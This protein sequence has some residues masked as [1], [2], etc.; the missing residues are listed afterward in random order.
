M[1]KSLIDLIKEL[2]INTYLYVFRHLPV[3]KNKVMLFTASLRQYNCNPK[4]LTEYLTNNRKDLDLVWV[5]E[6]VDNVEKLLP[7]GVRIVKYFSIR[8]LYEIYTAHYIITNARIGKGMMFS[9]RKNQKYIQLWHSSLRFKTIEQDAQD[10]LPESYII[11]ARKDSQMCDYIVSGSE[12]STKIFSTGFWYDG[13]VLKYGTPRVDY[14]L[15]ADTPSVKRK[16]CQFFGL[17]DDTHII[18]YAPTFRSGD[19]RYDLSDTEKIL[20]AAKKVYGGDWVIMERLHPNLLSKTSLESSDTVNA[21]YYD[22]MQE[23]LV[24]SEVLITDYSSCMFD[25]AYLKRQCI[26][27]VPDLDSYLANERKL[28]FDIKEL[29]F[30]IAYSGDDVAALIESYDDNEYKRSLT[31]FMDSIGSYECGK[32]SERISS[33]L[34]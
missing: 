23:L 25:F 8:Y 26:L 34:T 21:S 33:L 27:L 31:K 28:Y 29:P 19:Y 16:V 14:L 5:F 4:Y 7:E 12:F 18:L 6:N 15:N 3:K 22:D 10:T 2:R 13:P 9:K 24:A 17:N 30:G 20:C 1:G 32:A 11:Q